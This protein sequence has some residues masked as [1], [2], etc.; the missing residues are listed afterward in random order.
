MKKPSKKSSN[1]EAV[2]TSVGL[3]G[4]DVTPT[5][6][7]WNAGHMDALDGT[8]HLAIFP[9][10]LV[11]GQTCSPIC[12]ISP[13][14]KCNDRD[15][16]NARVIAAALDLLAACEAVLPVYQSMMEEQGLDEDDE[17]PFAMLKAAIARANDGEPANNAP[18]GAVA[19]PDEA[20]GSVKD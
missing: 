8:R 20:A 11:V 3:A 12:L 10:G 13:L 14:A 9:A 6:G 15:V 16:A 4:G 19:A 17:E 1:G 18:V 2:A 7:P 5:P